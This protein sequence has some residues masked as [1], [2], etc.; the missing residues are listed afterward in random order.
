[1]VIRSVSFAIGFHRNSL[2]KYNVDTTCNLVQLLGQF[3]TIYVRRKLSVLY[4]LNVEI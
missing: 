3:N 2:R 1:M 4:F